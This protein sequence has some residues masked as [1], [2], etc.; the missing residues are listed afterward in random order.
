[1]SD[2]AI[3][4][5]SV[6]KEIDPRFTRFVKVLAIGVGSAP[7]ACGAAPIRTG[8]ITLCAVTHDTHEPITGRRLTYA[9]PERFNGKRGGYALHSV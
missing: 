7:L 2:Q 8:F 6:W 4:L 5:G 3:A 9:Q 1:M